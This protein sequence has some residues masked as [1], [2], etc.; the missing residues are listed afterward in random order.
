MKHTR[1]T[2]EIKLW[3]LDLSEFNKSISPV[4]YIDSLTKRKDKDPYISMHGSSI[5]KS[6]QDYI[7]HDDIYAHSILYIKDGE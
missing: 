7:I 6:E 1:L 2:I 4:L 3:I 5:K